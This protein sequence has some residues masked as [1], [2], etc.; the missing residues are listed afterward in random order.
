MIE[1]RER[2]ALQRSEKAGTVKAEKELEIWE[3]SDSPDMIKQADLGMQ[4][5]KF[6]LADQKQ[7]LSQLEEMYSGTHLSQETKDIVLDRTRRGVQMGDEY[8]KLTKNDDL[9]TR[10]YRHPQRD[11]QVRETERAY[12]RRKTNRTPR[13]AS[14]RPK[15][16]RRWISRTLSGVK[17][18]EKR[19][20]DLQAD[21]KLR[22]V[23][24]Q[25]DGIMTTID[26]DPKDN[27]ERQTVC[28]VLDPTT[29]VVKFSA[30]PEDLRVLAP[31]GGVRCG[32]FALVADFPEVKLTGTITEMGEMIAASGGEANTIPVTVKIKGATRNRSCAWA[33]SARCRPS[34]R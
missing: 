11:E 30:Q 21:H 12:G 24:T 20:T 26:L 17:G 31:A 8:M 6:S 25:A 28:E 14:Q 27:I 10:Q 2:H 18:A 1:G 3:K 34:T 19:L 4:S 13:W 9:I 7:E 29:L 33:S 22:E 15:I 16:A 5:R 32:R 23:I